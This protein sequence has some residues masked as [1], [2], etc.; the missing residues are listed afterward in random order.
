MALDFVD[1]LP[2]MRKT[3]EAHELT[4]EKTEDGGIVSLGVFH[5]QEFV[6]FE[7]LRK[8]VLSSLKMLDKAIKGLVVMSAELEDMFNCFN[9]QKVPGVWEKKA[10]PCLKPLNAW[11]ADFVLRIEF[12][13]S[14]LVDGPPLSFW[15]PAF[16]FPQ[17]FMTA[18]LQLYA[19]E[20]QIAIDTLAF[21]TDPTSMGDG[22]DVQE[23]PQHGVYIHGL[24]FQGAG[25]NP[26]KLVLCESTP[27]QLFTLCPVVHLRPCLKDE[28]AEYI[29]TNNNYM[30]PCYKTSERKG[31]LS[32]TGHS[33][34]FVLFG[35]IPNEEADA[36]HW[37]RRGVCL[38]AMLD[39]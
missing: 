10:Y 39:D 15:V 20:T 21:S 3:K 25:F 5:S 6:R 22:P 9:I 35:N 8:A 12:M 16:F 38:L 24:Y 27:R 14:W 33:T 29:K 13:N 31:T 30:C 23:S 2:A 32:T 19:R 17:G 26:Y 1:R 18:S 34:N 11:F 28:L 36:N 4:Y 7:V 37:V